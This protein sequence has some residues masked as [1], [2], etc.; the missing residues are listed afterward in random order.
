MT[1]EANNEKNN[2]LL[3]P[4]SE[5]EGKNLSTYILTLLPKGVQQKIIKAFLIEDFSIC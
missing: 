1:P 2:K 5:L 4:K 3:T